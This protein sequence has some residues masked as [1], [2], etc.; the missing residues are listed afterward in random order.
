MKKIIYL[1]FIILLIFIF[2]CAGYE[3]IFS[4][5]NLQFEIAQYSLKGDKQLANKFY[6][7]VISFIDTQEL[8]QV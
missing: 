1:K 5:T 7:P 8:I 2:G 4:S 3:P 6:I